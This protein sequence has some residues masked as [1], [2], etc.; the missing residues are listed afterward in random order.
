[1]KSNRECWLRAR[2]PEEKAERRQTILE[3]AARLFDSGGYDGVSLNGLAREV[4]LAK[5][6]LYR[7]FQSKEAIFLAILEDEHRA[8]V[9][10]AESA[11]RA[12][13]SPATPEVV[14]GAVAST[15]V[16]RPR[17]CALAAIVS[18]VLEKN[19]DAER[20]LAHK[21][22]SVALIFRLLVAVNQALPA[23]TV[24]KGAT[25]VRLAYVLVTGL[26]PVANPPEAV[27]EVLARPEFQHMRADFARDLE[28]GL[29]LLLRGMIAGGDE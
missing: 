6:A 5:S 10:E 14:A 27:S 22:E 25:F 13:S 21:T 16:A 20:I 4:G 1:M 7:Y 8:W 15:L 23:I 2:R 18:G 17:L 3:T 24:D 26:W 11:L 29:T 12:L 9:E 28:L 19:I